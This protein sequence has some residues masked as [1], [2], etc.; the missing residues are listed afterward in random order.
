[1]SEIHPV[2]ADTPCARCGAKAWRLLKTQGV[3]GT[4]IET[5]ECAN[6]LCMGMQTAHGREPW[7]LS[8]AHEGP[9][10]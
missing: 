1:M 4:T 9:P 8:W 2:V 5:Y 3:R 10:S 7:P 6:A